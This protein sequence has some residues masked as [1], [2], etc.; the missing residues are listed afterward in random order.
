M[1]KPDTVVMFSLKLQSAT[2]VQCTAAPLTCGSSRSHPSSCTSGLMPCSVCMVAS[3]FVMPHCSGRKNRRF[4]FASSTL[5]QRV[6]RCCI[7]ESGAA[8]IAHLS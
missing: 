6:R 4:M 7:A 1:A 5:H 8:P 2:R 3:V